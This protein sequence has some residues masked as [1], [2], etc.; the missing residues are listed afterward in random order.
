MNLYFNIRYCIVT[1]P[2]LADMFKKPV[3]TWD[4]DTCMVTNK[5]DDT[6]CIACE[7][8]KPGCKATTSK[9][10]SLLT[11]FTPTLLFVFRNLSSALFY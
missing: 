6:K 9:S 10:D 8:T 7:M 3:G 5:G 11:S 1:G 4:C 2:S